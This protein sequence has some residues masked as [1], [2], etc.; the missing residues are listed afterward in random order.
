AYHG[1]AWQTPGR[2]GRPEQGESDFVLAH[3]RYGVL[4]LEVKGGNIRFDAAT[5]A[6][7]ST[8]KAG[9]Q[10]IKDPVAQA[11]RASHLLERTLARAKRSGGET[12]SFGHAVAFPDCRVERKTLKTDLPRDLVLD[13]GDLAQL[14]ER[15]DGLFR[16]WFDQHSKQP[17]EKAGLE[18]VDSVLARSFDLPSPLVFELRDEEQHLFRLTEQ[19]F[20]VLDMLSRNQ[21]AAIAGCAGSGKTFLAVEKARRLAAQGFRPLIVVFNVLLADHLRRGLRDVPE[22]DVRAFYGLCRDVADAARIE[23]PDEPEPDG[24]G[25]YYHELAAIFAEHSTALEGRWDAL[26]VDE[27]QDVSADWWLPLQLL[28]PMPDESPLYVFFDDNQK[29]FAVPTGLPMLDHAFQ[30]TV[31]CRNTKRINELVM[32]FY[33]GGTQNASGP[34]GP[35]IDRHVCATEKELLEQLDEAVADWVGQAEVAPADVALLSGYAAHRSALWKVDALGGIRLTDDPWEPN[36]IFRCSVFRFKGLE[37][38]VVGL[39]ELDGVREQALYVGLSRPSVFL[40][41]FASQKAMSRLA[42]V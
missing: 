20:S 11:R 2:G 3:P 40:S 18:L 5:G 41:L 24:E 37:R 16:Y 32:R 17:L 21:R 31:N 25:A 30:L 22:I 28:L 42:S 34:D 26:I 27:G 13:H 8:G 12:V 9:E 33:K 35:P 39:C 36:A 4:T 1:V 7:T 29:L 38:M 15:V 19:Q 6:W 10:R 23:V 14:D